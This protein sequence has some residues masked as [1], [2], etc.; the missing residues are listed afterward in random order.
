[1]IA[2]VHYTPFH[3]RWYRKPVSVWWWLQSWVYAKFVLRELTSLGVA[4]FALVELWKFHAIRIGADAYAQFLDRMKSPLFFAL[5]GLAIFLVLFHAVTW[6]NLTPK[7]MVVRLGARRV[8]DRVIVGINYL[9][10]IV[11]SVFLAWLS[12]R[13]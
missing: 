2:E 10:W 12:Q 13:G 11:V 3:P 7:A 6:V 5:N 9:A 1:M 8:P 4:Y